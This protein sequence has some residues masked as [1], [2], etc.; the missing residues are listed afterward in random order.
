MHANKFLIG[1][2]IGVHVSSIVNWGYQD[3]FKPI[4]LFI[5]FFDKKTL[6][7]QKAQKRK[8]NNFDPLKSLCAHK[9]L[10]SLLFSVSLFLFC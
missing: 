4:Y 10:L 6:H 1:G 5:Y 9:K 7:A 2:F 3:N 8:T